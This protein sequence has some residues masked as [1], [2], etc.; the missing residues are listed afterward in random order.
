MSIRRFFA[1]AAFALA[2][3][4]SCVENDRA[5]GG[6]LI[7]EDFILETGTATFSLPFT[8]RPS[9]SVQSSNSYHILVGYMNDP[10]YGT[11]VCDG[12]SFVLPLSDTSDLGVSPK[13]ISAYINLSIDSTYLPDASQE[14]IPQNITIYEL[15]TKMDSLGIFNNSIT[16]D[17]Y[18]PVPVNKGTPVIYGDGN[19]RIELTDEYAGKLLATTVDEYQDFDLFR[20]RIKGLYIKVDTPPGHITGGRFNYLQFGTSVI[21]VNFTMNDPER[22]I[23]DRDTTESFVFG[24]TYAKNYFRS[25]SGTLANDDPDETLYA[26]SLSG[27]KPHIS[28]RALKDTLEKWLAGPDING[29]QVIVSRACIDMPYKEPADYEIFETE[30]PEYLYAFTNTPWA[31]DSLHY[32]MPL[33]EIDGVASKGTP[34][35]SLMQYTMDVTSYIQNLILA[36]PDSV[37]AS[38]DLWIAP[39]NVTTDDETDMT[40][41]MFDNRN[42]R[43]VTLEG[44]AV[45]EPGRRPRLT[46]TYGLMVP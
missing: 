27:I 26:E 4:A 25:T 40:Y 33:P 34:N 9:D 18:S 22:G 17:D 6:G 36:D 15:N 13:L 28:A 24:Y 41:Y 29:R 14:G 42:Y 7:S 39:M 21:T 38:Y 10:V 35:R 11:T 46:V 23:I 16:E 5:L 31:T 32:Y 1:A 44:P 2:C 8:N 30:H 37:D 45:A 19:I 20:D 3:L 12:A 43:R